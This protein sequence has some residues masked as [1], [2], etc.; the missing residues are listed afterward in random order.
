M[1]VKCPECGNEFGNRWGAA[2]H[3]GHLHDGDVPDSISPHH[4][5]D[6]RQSISDSLKG[7][8][9]SE[10][11]KQKLSDVLSDGRM[12][13]KNHP[14]YG[15]R[16]EEHPA[17]GADV[18]SGPDHY[19]W[20]GGVRFRSGAPKYERRQ[21]LL[22]DQHRCCMCGRPEH[23][24]SK[25]HIHHLDHDS[26]NNESDNLLTLCADCHRRHHSIHGH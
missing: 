9:T 24:V 6:A 8:E 1:S 14:L 18:P 11:T 17:H 26:T 25:L 7:R 4:T 15:V 12:S 5:D 10:S 22:R 20:K 19:A 3:W 23:K 13:G 16:G 21:T 2:S